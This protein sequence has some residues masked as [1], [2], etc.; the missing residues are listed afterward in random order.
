METDTFAFA[1]SKCKTIAQRSF[2]SLDQIKMKTNL[3]NK[4]FV[5]L[6]DHFSHPIDDEVQNRNE[7]RHQLKSI[8]K[9]SMFPTS[10]LTIHQCPIL[11]NRWKNNSK[12]RT[13]VWIALFQSSTD[14]FSF[15]CADS[16]R[17][18]FFITNLT[19]N[20][21]ANS[22]LTVKLSQ[23]FLIEENPDD[24]GNEEKI[25]YS[26]IELLPADGK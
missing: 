21:S 1:R 23:L 22:L 18:T 7:T 24:N 13:A 6:F 15:S 14:L 17:T 20:D 9:W 8:S 19:A 12:I 25:K 26:I 16:V 2:K 3:S 4:R 10:F 5:V 11:P